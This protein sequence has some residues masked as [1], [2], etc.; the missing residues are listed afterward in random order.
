MS[1]VNINAQ[2]QTLVQ[3]VN[4]ESTDELFA[5]D[6][7]ANHPHNDR[8]YVFEGQAKP[9]GDQARHPKDLMVEE[10]NETPA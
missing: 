10:K 6:T 7:L 8:G 3:P 9:D 1:H 2:D 4:S 5:D